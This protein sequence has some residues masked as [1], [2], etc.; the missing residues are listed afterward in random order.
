MSD[1]ILFIGGAIDTLMP[2]HIDIS[3]YERY[4]DIAGYNVGNLVY[5]LYTKK[6]LEYDKE[7]SIHVMN[8]NELNQ[9]DF[10][11][12]KFDKIVIF[13]A[14]QINPNDTYLLQFAN[15]LEKTDLPIIL[16]GLGCQSNLDYSMDF[17]NLIPEHIKF[18]NIL[19][20][21]K[22]II[23]AR[24]KFTKKCLD[25]LGISSTVIGCPSFYKNGQN[26]QLFNPIK[27]DILVDVS[28]DWIKNAEI[29][30]K[31]I[32]KHKCDVICQSKDEL[33]LYKYSISQASGEDIEKIRSFLSSDFNT[34]KDDK[35]FL[36]HCHIFFKI[37]DW[38]NFIKTRDFYI[39]PKI[40]GC[41]MNILN[42]K[43]AMLIVHDSRTREFAEYFHIPHIFVTDLTEKINFSQIYNNYNKSDIEENY[44]KILNQYK[45]FL[46]SAN[47]KNSL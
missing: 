26:F 30:H 28:C 37:S 10:S 4:F 47:L 38:E 23:G 1:K 41:L 8:I 17:L 3:E 43:P 45:E 32:T 18:L 12:R 15:F 35:S 13:C 31:L 34:T 29:W 33:S 46:K 25:K 40:H 22:A 24:G 36:G 9:I 5:T 7:N 16:L 44:F 39:G 42:G 19:K 14:N 27:D 21:K 6:Y 20:A 11:K 2:E